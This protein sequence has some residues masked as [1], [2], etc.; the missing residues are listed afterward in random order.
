M[1]SRIFFKVVRRTWLFLLKAG[2]GVALS[3]GGGGAFRHGMDSDFLDGDLGRSR[4]LALSGLGFAR[5][6]PVPGLLAP[7]ADLAAGLG[8]L[9]VVGLGQRGLRLG[10]TRR[11]RPTCRR[12]RLTLGLGLALRLLTLGS[13]TSSGR[14]AV[15]GLDSRLGLTLHH[16]AVSA[17]ATRPTLVRLLINWRLNSLRSRPLATIA[18]TISPSRPGCASSA[19]V[20]CFCRRSRY[21]A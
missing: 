9:R 13:A 4:T 11:L 14:G 19:C 6:V 12:T 5:R 21:A 18:F 7:P 15:L 1:S 20:T 17:W 2:Q 16:S 10:L 3:G 8:V